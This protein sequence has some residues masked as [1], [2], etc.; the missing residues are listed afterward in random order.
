MIDVETLAEKLR[1]VAGHEYPAWIDLNPVL[2]SQ[3][4]DVA[5]AAVQLRLSA[6]RNALARLEAAND[7]TGVRIVG[8]YLREV[9]G[10][11]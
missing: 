4:R 3:W 7:A 8:E 1:K 10:H 11:E 2:K 5:H 6:L 9:E